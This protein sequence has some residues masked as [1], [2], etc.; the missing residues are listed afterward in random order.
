[1][2]REIRIIRISCLHVSKLIMTNIIEVK[3]LTKKYGNFTAVDD[4]SFEYHERR[5]FC[6]PRS[7]WRR[8]NDD[9]Q[10]AHHAFEADER[11]DIA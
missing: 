7:E 2:K 3:N 6:V 4:I 1:M 9:D 11:R 10:D 8:Q 5:D